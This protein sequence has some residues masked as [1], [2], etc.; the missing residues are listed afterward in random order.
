MKN[1]RVWDKSRVQ[2]KMMKI[3][4]SIPSTPRNTKNWHRSLKNDKSS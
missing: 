2:N 3:N 4:P 1:H